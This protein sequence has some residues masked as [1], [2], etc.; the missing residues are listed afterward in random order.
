[1]IFS[2]PAVS[3]SC[4]SLGFGFYMI[5]SNIFNINF[6]LCFSASSWTFG[7]LG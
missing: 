7:A 6:T 4:F 5:F 2:A 1:M 3:G